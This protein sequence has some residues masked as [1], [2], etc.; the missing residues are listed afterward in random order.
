[1]WSELQQVRNVR[2][3]FHSALGV[4][5]G[6]VY[7]GSVFYLLRGREPWTFKVKGTQPPAATR[8]AHF[9][10]DSCLLAE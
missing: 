2:P 1:M 9:T 4:Y 5:G 6:I 7:T 10:P 3:S 8:R